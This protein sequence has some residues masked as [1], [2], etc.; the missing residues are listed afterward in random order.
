[1]SKNK[2]EAQMAILYSAE[3]MRLACWKTKARIQRHIDNTKSSYCK[4]EYEIFTS[5]TIVQ[6]EPTVAFP[7][8]D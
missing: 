6:R 1:M 4:Q 8:H 5:S 2:V 7:W 3:N